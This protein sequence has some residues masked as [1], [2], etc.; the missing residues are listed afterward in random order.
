MDNRYL[1]VTL[2][3]CIV[4]AQYMCR[5]K[6]SFKKDIVNILIFQRLPYQQRER[7]RCGVRVDPGRRFRFSM[8]SSYSKHKYLR[9]GNIRTLVPINILA[10]VFVNMSALPLHAQIL[11]YMIRKLPIYDSSKQKMG[12]PIELANPSFI[13]AD[14]R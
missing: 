12:Q 5:Y 10:Y 14:S 7:S 13:R 9:V 11:I 3:C 8:A 1:R 2:D 6:N 4:S